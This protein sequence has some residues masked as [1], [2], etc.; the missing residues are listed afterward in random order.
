MRLPR[1]TISKI[2]RLRH[3]FNRVRDEDEKKW[4]MADVVAYIVEAYKTP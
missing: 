3:D 4:S 2:D 1:E